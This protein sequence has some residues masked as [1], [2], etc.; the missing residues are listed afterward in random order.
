MTKATPAVERG[1]SGCAEIRI[2]SLLPK[3]VTTFCSREGSR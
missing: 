2:S 1:F 3:Q